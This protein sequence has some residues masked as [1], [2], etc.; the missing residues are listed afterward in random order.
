MDAT[1][2]GGL[3]SRRGNRIEMEFKRFISPTRTITTTKE[4]DRSSLRASWTSPSG[5]AIAITDPS[6]LSLHCQVD[7]SLD[8][9]DESSVG[10]A[11]TRIPIEVLCVYGCSHRGN[12]SARVRKSAGRRWTRER[13][14]ECELISVLFSHMHSLKLLPLLFAYSTTWTAMT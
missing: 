11:R 5:V 14:T 6:S 10:Y 8:G 1:R 12:T 2:L 7:A 3:F 9:I 13:R 4:C